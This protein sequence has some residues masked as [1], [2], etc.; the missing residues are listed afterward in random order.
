VL[1]CQP[2]AHGENR[3]LR[4]VGQ[5]PRHALVAVEVT[6]HPAAAMHPDQDAAVGC[7]V[8]P[9]VTWPGL[10][11]LAV[12]PRRTGQAGRP[13]QPARR[14]GDGHLVNG[15]DGLQLA[16]HGQGLVPGLAPQVLDG[17]CP[18]RRLRTRCR[19]VTPYV[20]VRYGHRGL[21]QLGHG[22]SPHAQLGCRDPEDGDLP[23]PE[24]RKQPG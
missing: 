7:C 22:V 9:A 17:P 8:G 19:E 15:R 11:A 6:V 4:P 14:T 1:G 5:G 2:V 3:A 16:A 20:F 21:G 24:T 23:K 10:L 18:R 12:L 13:V